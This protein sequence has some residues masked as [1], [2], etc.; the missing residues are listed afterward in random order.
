MIDK[1]NFAVP[2]LVVSELEFN[3]GTKGCYA[4]WINLWRDRIFVTSVALWTLY[5][6]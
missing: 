6:S 2:G 3:L 1:T 4:T 5:H